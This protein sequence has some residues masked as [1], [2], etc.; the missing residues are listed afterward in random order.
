MNKRFAGLV[1]TLAA[2]LSSLAA[3]RD[4]L[5]KKVDEAIQKGLPRTAITNLEP[6]IAG[7]LKDK[8]Y[9][10]AA[11]AIARKIVLEGNIQGNKPEEKITRM[12]AE[13][14]KAPEEILPLLRHASGPLVL[15]LFPA[16][17]LAVHAAHRHGRAARPGFHHLGPAPAVCRDRQAV[18]GRRSQPPTAQEDA[19]E[20]AST[21]CWKKGLCRTPI[22]PRSTTFIAHEA[23]KFYTSGEQAGAKPEDAFELS[24][25]SPIFGSAEEFLA[26]KPDTDRHRFAQ[27]KAFDSTRI[28]CRFH[29]KDQ[30]PTALR[31]CWTWPGCNAGTTSPS[32]RTRTPAT[33]PPSSAWSRQWADH[34]LSAFATYRW[35]RVVH[36]EGELVEAR[37]LAQR[38]AAGLPG[39]HRRQKS[40]TTSSRKSRPSL[41][42]SPPSGSGTSPGRRSP[43][44]TAM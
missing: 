16:E 29:E 21:I 11:K 2:C 43:S 31:R 19:G 35:A 3:A 33:R 39:Q 30:D 15:A 28:C 17:P 26:W 34:E 40:A 38:G 25:D 18:S 37:A 10:E 32:A 22:G 9:G 7:A 41:P 12:D 42:A 6:I 20:P 14:A 24:A 27:L 13:I 8:A 4:D 1:L 36:Q 23:L 5:W 44:A